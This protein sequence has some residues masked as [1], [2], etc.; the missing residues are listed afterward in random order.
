MEAGAPF[1]DGS[2]I[3]EYSAPCWSLE[4]RGV[5]DA[6]GGNSHEG[7]IGAPPRPALLFTFV[8]CSFVMK[9]KHKGQRPREVQSASACHHA[10]A[11]LIYIYSMPRVLGGTKHQHDTKSSKIGDGHARAHA[12]GARFILRNTAGCWGGH[13]LNECRPTSRLRA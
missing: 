6:G 7:A 5:T 4:R 12:P 10:L 9:K 3:Q 11:V 1:H 8:V 2:E 13:H